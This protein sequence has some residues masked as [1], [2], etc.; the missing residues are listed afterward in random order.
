MSVA[1]KFGE[2]IKRAVFGASSLRQQAAI[3]LREPQSEVSVSLAGPG[4]CRDVTGCNVMAAARPLTFG[5]GF[6]GDSDVT[7]L[8]QSDPLLEFRERGGENRLLGTIRLRWMEAL[9]LGD[10][11]LHL[12]RPT[13]CRNYCLSPPQLWAHYSYYAWRRWRARMRRSASAARMVPGELHSLF[14]FYIC[15]RP[16]ALVSVTDGDVANIFPMDLIGPI[17]TQ[18]FALALH[19]TSTAV[20]LIERSL[21][22]ALSNIPVERKSTA[23]DLGRNHKRPGVNWP[24]LPFATSPSAAFRIPVPA[25][26]LRVREMQIEAVRALGSHKLFLATTVR[27]ERRADG[28]QL[29][30]VHGIYQARREQWMGNLHQEMA[31]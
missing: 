29:C 28:A 13:R 14:V 12:F 25:F 23:Y 6:E 8:R 27:D 19:H 18:H 3:G 10:D 24:E 22:I 20:P 11:R 16:V 4:I 21:R 9:R 26:S 17:G 2:A 15:P 1:Q 30:M 7:A 5:I 31:R